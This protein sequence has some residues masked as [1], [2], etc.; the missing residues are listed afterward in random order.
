MTHEFAFN[1]L[2]AESRYLMELQS[3]NITKKIP[4]SHTKN[5]PTF[6]VPIIP[7]TIINGF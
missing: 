1:E 4:G 3:G 7:E 6:T 2:V 5:L